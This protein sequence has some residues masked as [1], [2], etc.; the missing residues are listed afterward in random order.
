GVSVLFNT[1]SS[2]ALNACQFVYDRTS[3]TEALL[4]DGANG[5]NRRS[6][7]SSTVL[8]NSA[9]AIGQVTMLSSGQ[10]LTLTIPVT[11]K[12]PFAGSKNIYLYA[13][14]GLVNTGWVQR[15]TY[16]VTSTGGVALAQS[17]SPSS[18]SGLTQTFTFTIADAGGASSLTGAAMLI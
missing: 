9:C 5:S 18:G 15:G 8:Q 12:A 2:L 14:A 6:V 13:A 17:V 16:T 10:N 4:W 7:G 11:F 1:T 3:N